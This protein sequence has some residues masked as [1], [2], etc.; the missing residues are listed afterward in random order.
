MNMTGAMFAMGRVTIATELLEE[1][2]RFYRDLLGMQVSRDDTTTQEDGTLMGLSGPVKT[3]LVTLQGGDK[4]SGKVG[5]LQ[6]LEPAVPLAARPNGQSPAAALTFRVPSIDAT[7]KRAIELGLP[8]TSP[9]TLMTIPEAGQVKTLALRDPNGFLVFLLPAVA[10]SPG[11]PPLECV[12]MVVPADSVDDLVAFYRKVLGLHT[13]YDHTLEL[14]D[15]AALG[16]TGPLAVRA[17][18]MQADEGKSGRV[19]LLAAVGP[20]TSPPRIDWPA[21]TAHPL[22]LFFAVWNMEQLESDLRDVR[23]TVVAGPK[24]LQITAPGTDM[25]VNLVG[26]TCLDPAGVML[27]IRFF[28]T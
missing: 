8:L 11:G 25:V 3:R 21:G 10:E 12:S 7:Y 14:A 15:G 16:S 9:P 20:N 26:L 19:G 23:A 18:A 2:T 28:P 5:L 1:S 22:A 27:D 24:P 4:Q 13:E 6:F 17:V